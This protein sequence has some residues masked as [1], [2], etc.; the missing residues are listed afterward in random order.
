[1]DEQARRAGYEALRGAAPE[2][3]VN[4]PGAPIELL[5]DPADVAAAERQAAETLA[6]DGLPTEWAGTGVATRA[7]SCPCCRRCASRSTRRTRR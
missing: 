2:A 4:P 3:F 5:L 7:R 1:M 6:A